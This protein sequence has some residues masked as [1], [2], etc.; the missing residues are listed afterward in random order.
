LDVDDAL[1]VAIEAGLLQATTQ[2]SVLG[3]QDVVILAIGTP[4][5]EW[6]N[7]DEGQF[8]RS[9]A[10]IVDAM[11]DGQLLILRST[12]MPGTTER[13]AA[14]V[15]TNGRKLA[16]AYCPDRSVEGGGP[17]ELSK[18]PQLVAGTTPQATR[19]AGELF[20]RLG[21]AI[22][23][24]RPVE[25]ELGKLFTNAYRYITFAAANH[26]YSAAE[27]L[28]VDFQRI[29]QAIMCDYPRMVDFPQAGFAA[30]PCLPK[31]TLQLAAF[32]L[33][34]SPL[35]VAAVAINEGLPKALVEQAKSHFNLRT[36]TTGILGMAF[37]CESDDPRGSLAY[38]LRKILR[39]ESRQV[40]CTDP[41]IRNS[42]FVSLERALGEADL[43]FV[44]ACHAEYRGLRFRQPVIDC[45]GL[46]SHDADVQL[47][48]A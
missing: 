33:A 47:R 3:D 45:F 1:P 9:C 7:P 18:H 15:A 37:K 44:G 41:Y 39:L 14:D 34:A 35:A 42:G 8:Q 21:L 28:G 38:K 11:R 6:L 23:E 46:L 16:V 26:F 31:D 36:M 20:R 4:L 30:G 19:R 22:I 5:D 27:R 32:D 10:N 48:A 25:A 12:V 40:L 2:R 17:A 43:L 13:L 24:L 29:R